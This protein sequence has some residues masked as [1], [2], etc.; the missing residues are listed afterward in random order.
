MATAKRLGSTAFSDSDPFDD[1]RPTQKR[2]VLP[3]AAEEQSATPPPAVAEAPTE[4]VPPDAEGLSTPVTPATPE[5]VEPL[6]VES[7]PVTAEA[8]RPKSKPATPAEP[9]SPQAANRR[10]RFSANVAV[11]I[12]ERAEN[13]SYWI[14]GMTISAITEVA[15]ER[16]LRRLEKEHN[17]GKPFER[18][19]KL[20]YGRPR[21]GDEG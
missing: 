2:K 14:P 8:P 12:K 4:Q 21:A 6:R 7:H 20:K 1:L 15:L 18:A 11:S 5:H 9:S 13:A 16:E 19:G 10:V 17:D 3:F